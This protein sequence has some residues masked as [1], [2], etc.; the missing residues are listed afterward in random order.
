[1]PRAGRVLKWLVGGMVA[2]ACAA[3][4]AVAGYGVLLAAS[5]ALPKS[6]EHPP[7]LIFGAPHLLKPG[8]PVVET[9]VFDRLHR[10][11]YRA[12]SDVQAP[13]D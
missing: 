12:V 5:I 4:V 3:I 11:G 2:L 8:E 9:G 7:L 6:D 1:M 10:L 13:G